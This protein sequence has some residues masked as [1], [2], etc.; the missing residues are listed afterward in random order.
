MGTEAILRN[1][2]TP[3][4]AMEPGYRL[5]RT[6]LADGS[7]KESFLAREEPDA[8]VVRLPGVE[9]ERIALH[10]VHKSGFV[11]CSLMLEGLETTYT[12]QQWTDLFA[13]LKTLR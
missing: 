5:Y 11:H 3:N 7:L 2:L 13:Y 4:A 1:I 9:D 6:E 8:I 10:R 12:P